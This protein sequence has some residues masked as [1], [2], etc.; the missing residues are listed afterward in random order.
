L[1]PDSK[2]GSWQGAGGTLQPPWLFRRKANPSSPTKTPDAKAS[3][4]LLFSLDFTVILHQ[5]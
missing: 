3:S 2:G 5:I 1:E 4:V